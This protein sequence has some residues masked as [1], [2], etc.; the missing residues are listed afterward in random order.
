MVNLY[1]EQFGKEKREMS[2][3]L[4]WGGHKMLHLKKIDFEELLQ[5]LEVE[6]LRTDKRS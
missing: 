2:V 1:R 3:I 6:M 5:I 4:R